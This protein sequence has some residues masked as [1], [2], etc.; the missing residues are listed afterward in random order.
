MALRRL[1]APRFAPRS[2]FGGE[3]REPLLIAG[4][5]AI[6]VFLAGTRWAG[7]IGI[8]PI[9]LPDVLLVCGVAAL[10]VRSLRHPAQFLP[11]TGRFPSALPLL[12]VL[13]YV[14]VR[15]GAGGDFSIT[16]IR[17]V[18]P[19]LY[20]AAALLCRYAVRRA[21]DAARR[22]TLRVLV[23]VLVFHAAW[24]G[25]QMLDPTL[26]LSLP[27]INAVQGV[28]LFTPRP[29]V[30]TSLIG[31]L[32]ALILW[33]V[34]R[35][36]QYRWLLIVTYALC[37][38]EIGLSF[39]RA[40]VLGG[41]VA[42]AYVVV[43]TLFER[44]RNVL[45]RALIAAL[46]PLV[47]VV[48]LAAVAGTPVGVKFIATVDP[49]AAPQS[50]AAQGAIGTTRA[51]EN[52]WNRLIDWTFEDGTRTAVGV[53]FGP[54]FL[55]QS[56]AAVLLVGDNEDAETRPRSPHDYWLGSMARLGL[57]GLGLL[58]VAVG[59]FLLTAWRV[60]RGVAGDPFALLLF[61]IPLSLLLPAS[62]GVVLES[63]Y[64]AMPFWWALGGAMVA[65]S[66]G[67]SAAL[68]LAARVRARRELVR[69]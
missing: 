16:A 25:L 23:G 46:V 41:A 67:P 63:P 61:L 24:Y 40:G 17:D 38:A 19:Y 57:I 8:A 35:E 32:A 48:G 37:W 51:R 53:G 28:N 43:V 39:T 60:R 44:R 7:Y 33:R 36:K 59:Q 21:N 50:T 27:S 4:T 14:V 65:V 5:L 1:E 58:V 12:V 56:G 22:R 18:V 47:L 49:A 26:P 30:D 29:D 9:Y 52:A 55:S 10:V 11:R 31:V 34:L 2:R 64:G 69:S 6:A 54:D 42:T 66:P 13:A 68:G 3:R 45:G 62:L 20:I 15:W